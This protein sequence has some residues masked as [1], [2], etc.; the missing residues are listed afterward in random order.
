M[1][2]SPGIRWLGYVLIFQAWLSLLRINVLG[3]NDM[4]AVAYDINE[5]ECFFD[6]RGNTPVWS[7]SMG[8]MK[9]H[10]P[11]LVPEIIEH[12]NV[13]N[14]GVYADCT[15]GQGG[16]SLALLEASE[17]DGLVLGIDRDGSSVAEANARLTVYSDR[18]IGVQGNYKDLPDI[19]VQNGFSSFD[20]ILLDLGFSSKQIDTDGYGLSFQKDEY[21]DMRFDR[22]SDCITASDIVNTFEETELA[23]LIYQYGEERS[24]RRI[25]KAI[26]RNR[27]LYT[28]KELSET[29]LRTINS[30]SRIHPATRTFQ[31]LRIRVNDELHNLE[32]GL[33]NIVSLL[34]RLGRLGIISYHSLE[35]RVVKSTLFKESSTCICSPEL[36]ECLCEHKPRL[37]LINRRVIKPTS[38]EIALNP[39]SRSARL[40]IAENIA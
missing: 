2:R 29:I 27:P 34:S 30:R 19:A 39:R 15:L 21:L 3:T 28:T 1:A 26:V 25:A 36:L 35:D 7:E 38:S 40:R 4:Q 32:I 18:F 6:A 31:A 17:P 20:G 5:S 11:V 12:L 24:S 33:Q 37:R 8:S 23:N 9:F 13:K 10:L 16:H 14:A 22:D